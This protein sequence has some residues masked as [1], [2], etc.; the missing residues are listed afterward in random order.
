MKHWP[1]QRLGIECQPDLGLSTSKNK[2]VKKKKK[3]GATL[4]GK[5]IY[6]LLPVIRVLRSANHEG[7]GYISFVYQPITVARSHVTSR[8]PNRPFY[9]LE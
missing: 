5:H 8:T 7:C 4:G 9:R 2:K 1:K 3:V 6:K